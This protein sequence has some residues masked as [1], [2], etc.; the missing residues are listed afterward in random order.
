MGRF[1]RQ[2]GSGVARYIF[3]FGGPQIK[4]SSSTLEARNNADTAY[5]N[6]HT[7]EDTAEVTDATTNA[8]VWPYIGIHDLSAG[9]GVAGIGAGLRL[10]TF[11]GAG[12]T[13]DAGGY[14]AVL[15]DVTAGAEKGALDLL[16]RTGG[17]LLQRARIW[18]D[19]GFSIG[20]VYNVSPGA[21]STLIPNASVHYGRNNAGGANVAMIAI[22]TTDAIVLGETSRRTKYQGASNDA[23]ATETIS[24]TTNI[25]ALKTKHYVDTSGGAAV[26]TLPSTAIVGD[27]HRTL[28]YKGTASVTN[29]ITVNA[30]GGATVNGGAF[31]ASTT[32]YGEMEFEL[33]AANTWVKA[34]GQ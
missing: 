21:G 1:T 22:D 33:V 30:P 23:G 15:T 4:R 34:V 3:G 31:I 19:G 6:V 5:A 17:T 26:L 10:R 13:V 8:I 29:S 14:A 9:V 12:T 28:D 32:P 20:V 2:L 18:D 16:V 27:I 24:G 11:N 25:A 7:A